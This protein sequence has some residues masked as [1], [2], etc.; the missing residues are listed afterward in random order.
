[1]GRLLSRRIC[2]LYSL[3]SHS[4]AAGRFSHN[5]KRHESSTSRSGQGGPLTRKL[6]MSRSYMNRDWNSWG[7]RDPCF[8]ALSDR[9]YLGGNLTSNALGDL[10]ARGE[11]LDKDIC[12]VI[13][14][15]IRPD[16]RADPALDY[17]CGPGRLAI[18]FAA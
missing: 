15:T 10:P 9:K 6:Q 16:F 11:R 13:R 7:K 5:S 17:R 14:A 4:R 12:E 3:P 2:S 18:P 1:M 8:G